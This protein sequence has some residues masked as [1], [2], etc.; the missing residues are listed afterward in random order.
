MCKDGRCNVCGLTS[1]YFFGGFDKAGTC[2][3]CRTFVDKTTFFKGADA[4]KR[5]VNLQPGEKLG[6][7]VSGGKDSIYLWARMAEIFGADNV[8][9]FCYYRPGITHPLA[10]ENIRNTG[11]ILGAEYFVYTDKTAYERLKINFRILLKNPQ[12]AAV[13]V[14]LCSGCR[15]GITRTL[16]DMGA[17]KGIT[18]YISGASYLELAPFKEEYLQAKSIHGDIDEGF[19]NL[20]AEYPQL[21]F[22]DNLDV[23]RR[24]QR[25]KYKNND[26]KD[27]NFRS[28]YDYELFDYDNYCENN[29]EEIEKYVVERF[30]WQKSDRSWHFDCKIEDFKDALY[31]GMLG[32]TECDFKYSAMVRYGLLTR[33]ESI[34]LTEEHHR[35]IRNGLS[36]LI[37][38]LYDMGLEELVPDLARFY[39]ESAFLSK[40]RA[41]K[42]AERAVESAERTVKRAEREV[43]SAERT[44]KRAERAVKPVERTA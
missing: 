17:E 5:D 25:F 1:D 34:R 10:M 13:R 35:S 21:D 28:G 16:H 15:Y 2:R 14:L 44:V 22:D 23:L 26:T 37:S 9:A 4:L 31:Y 3:T 43:K 12:P 42:S 11:R 29:P 36:G 18:K 38:K 30:N 24:D 7:T 41:V 27:N 20:L 40:E 32:Y 6:V 39:A 8:L 19:E 33:E